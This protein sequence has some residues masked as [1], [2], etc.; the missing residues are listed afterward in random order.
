MWREL[1]HA[2]QSIAACYKELLGIGTQKH[3]ALATMNLK[4]LE[5]VVKEEE[6]LVAKIERLEGDRKEILTEL[7]RR[8]EG[9]T[10][11]MKLRDL[12]RLCPDKTEAEALHRLHTE[13]DSLTQQVKDAGTGNT[14]LAESALAAVTA[15]L[16][17]IGGVS[18]GSSYGA[19]GEESV[20]RKQ[21][22]DF[23]A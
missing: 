3:K 23:Q 4:A 15:N 18:A 22:F 16:N 1:E 9:I 11:D 10:P 19:G 8:E 13:L 7:A 21:R 6:R 12:C 14:L 17:R 5:A 20:T 2:M